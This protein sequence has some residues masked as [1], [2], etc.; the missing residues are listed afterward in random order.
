MTEKVYMN[1]GWTFTESFTEDF[2]AGKEDSYQT[3][4]LPHTVKE[5][6]Y[7]YFDAEIYQ[8]VS[9]YRRFFSIPKEWERKRVFLVIEA[10]AHWAAV[11]LNGKKLCEHACGYT[12]FK[13]ELT[14]YLKEG[15][16][17]LVIEVDSRETLDQPP[18]GKVIDY[19]T[20]G[21]LYREVYL[22]VM[23]PIYLEDVFV[24]PEI[25][26]EQAFANFTKAGPN[27]EEWIEDIKNKTV[28][29]R[30]KSQIRVKN[31][32][33][34]PLSVKQTVKL[35][36]KAEPKD[37]GKI[38]KDKN[39]H[40]VDLGWMSLE[41]CQKV[42]NGACI[43]EFPI[44]QVFLWDVEA[45][46]LYVVTTELYEG[47]QLLDQ[48]QT[49]IGFRKAVFK[50]DGFYLNGRKLKLRGLN[51]HQSYPFVGY[52]M[53]AS[54]QKL[55]ADILKN[56][57]GVNSVRTSH[58]PCAPSFYEQCDEIGLL[59]F[60]EIPG[61]QNLGGA[62]WKEQVVENTKEM[63]LQNRNHPSIILW[64]VR[65][66]ESMDD[67]KLYEKTNQAAR[68]LDPTRQTGGV[69]YLKKSHL[70]EDVYTYNDFSYNGKTLREGPEGSASKGKD[71]WKGCEPKKNITSDTGKAFL[72]SEYNGHMYPT[73][74]FDCE[75]KR[76]EHALRHAAVL[77]SVAAQSDIAGSF[78]WCMF[79]YNT[80]REF[81]SG[82]YICH[83]GVMDMFRNPKFA[84]AVYKAQVEAT[85][86]LEISSSMD[87]GEHPEGVMGRVYIITNA[88]EVRFYRNGEFIYS[89]TQADSSF[90][91]LKHGPI[92]ITDYIGDQLE[93]K[94]GFSKA[95]AEDVKQILNYC[96]CFGLNDIPKKLI[97]K[98]AKLMTRYHMTMEQAYDLYGKYAGGWGS[99][100]MTFQFEAI[101]GGQIVKT[102]VKEPVRNVFLKAQADHTFLQEKSTYD[103]AAIRI[104]AVDQNGNVLPFYFGTVVLKAEGPIE[105]IGPQFV[106]IRGG[107]GGT[108]VKTDGKAEGKAQITLQ[109]ENASEVK[110]PFKVQLGN[111]KKI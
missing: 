109:M 49:T 56:E 54:M 73:K 11:F 48:K 12:A 3:V 103:V 100:N 102:I 6:P 21:G 5:T 69:R 63:I 80:H 97:A 34:I 79:D 94:E 74:T 71:V 111:S 1:D 42:E 44:P 45:P 37:A 50:S 14:P 30:L 10:A 27:A 75:D 62:K 23:D 20:Y 67:D 29:A 89:Y 51:R 28:P 86:V 101:Q 43:L 19:M 98:A 60:T 81:G 110:I 92:E 31:E 105:V 22:E 108:Y 83:H 91:N 25:L 99:Q 88:D 26:E 7:N 2:L 36:E 24:M 16:N 58:Y 38:K 64:G 17:L 77:D 57:L 90:Q 93:K 46:K 82:D 106:Q 59:V 18:F 107:Y 15:E 32:K 96:I 61:W 52:A 47:N 33:N 4:R 55:D 87:K 72:I 104:A 40:L 53:P 95:Q 70:L 85:P 78:G 8:M 66:N 76:T 13:T 68:S 41:N 65:V 9:G 84:A 35:K 39:D